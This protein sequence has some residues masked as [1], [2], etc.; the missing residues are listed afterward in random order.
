MAYK[1]LIFDLGNVIFGVSF[2]RSFQYW[3]KA[4]GQPAELLAER[5]KF[6]QDYEGFEKNAFEP[7]EFRS[8]ITRKLGMDIRDEEFDKGWNNLYMDV[9][10]GLDEFLSRLGKKYRLVALTNTNI[11]HETVW[12]PMFSDILKHF[13]TVFCSPAMGCR[14]PEREIYQKVLDEMQ[15]DASEV[16]FMDDNADN[17]HGARELGIDSILVESHEQMMRDVEGKLAK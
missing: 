3:A 14:K 8:R 6:D 15:L 4:S 10:P 1:A 9:Y 2:E 16:L 13:E 11:I 17:I 5:F 12:K 7:A